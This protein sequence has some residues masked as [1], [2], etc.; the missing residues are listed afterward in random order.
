MSSNKNKIKQQQKEPRGS[1]L[2]YRGAPRTPC[3][4]LGCVWVAFQ[5]GGLN[6]IEPNLSDLF[7]QKGDLKTQIVAVIDVVAKH[8]EI[9]EKQKK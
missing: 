1:S 8:S 9:I 7:F 2:C 5:D 4:A 3:Q 6:A